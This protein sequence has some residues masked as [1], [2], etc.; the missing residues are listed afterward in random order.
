[1]MGEFIMEEVVMNMMNVFPFVVV[2][3]PL[4][5]RELFERNEEA[6][7]SSASSFYDVIRPIFTKKYSNT[8]VLM[9]HSHMLH[10]KLI[11]TSKSVNRENTEINTYSRM[12]AESLG[13]Y[14]DKDISEGLVFKS[15]ILDSYGVE[16]DEWVVNKRDG[17]YPNIPPIG[18]NSSD[19]MYE[20][21]S[22]KSIPVSFII[23]GLRENFTS[24]NWNTVVKMIKTGTGYNNDKHDD[25]KLVRLP[26]EH[27]PSNSSDNYIPYSPLSLSPINLAKSTPLPELLNQLSDVQNKINN[28][29]AV[30]VV[31]AANV[32]NATTNTIANATTN[33]VVNATNA[34]TNAVA[35]AANVANVAATNVATNAANVANATTNALANL[36]NTAT[37]VANSAT[38]IA[39]N[40]ANA[41]ATNASNVVANATSNAGIIADN[42]GNKI[43]DV[44]EGDKPILSVLTDIATETTKKINPTE[45][46]SD[47][48][49]ITI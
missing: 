25:S 34:T 43:M 26:N 8:K 20:D 17:K 37:N 36:T 21:G 38:N 13:W 6:S 42:V 1:M 4:K 30:N 3:L 14:L 39:T 10:N 7:A 32:A 5:H 40:A 48:K 31:N 24:D 9:F 12:N 19:L 47:V 23:N 11:E 49:K 27:I 45:N 15:I 41:A 28:Y 44:V 33:A 16:T 35:N 18:W 46:K 22:R 29:A 2:K